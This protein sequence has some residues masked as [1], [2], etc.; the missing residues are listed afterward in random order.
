MSPMDYAVIIGSGILALLV[1]FF[2]G[3]LPMKNDRMTPDQRTWSQVA[4][5]IGIGL[6]VVLILIGQDLASWVAIGAMVAGILI[7]VIPAI[8]QTMQSRFVW[9]RPGEEPD[10]RKP[11]KGSPHNK[12]SSR[13]GASRGGSSKGW[14]TNKKQ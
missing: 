9:L 13:R 7:G 14:E 12:K 1:G 8:K 11:G 5:L 2:F 3:L 10:R 6:V 4:S